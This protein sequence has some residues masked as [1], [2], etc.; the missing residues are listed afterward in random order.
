MSLREI[1]LHA[2]SADNKTTVTLILSNKSYVSFEMAYDVK[3]TNVQRSQIILS[4]SVTYLM[5]DQPGE[6]LQSQNVEREKHYLR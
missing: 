3:M 1:I 2:S 6:Y 5:L 4:G